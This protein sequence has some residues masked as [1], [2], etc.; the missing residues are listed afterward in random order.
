[1]SVMT[2]DILGRIPVPLFMNFEGTRER[3]SES[4]FYNLKVP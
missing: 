3:E 4:Q 2:K 1:M